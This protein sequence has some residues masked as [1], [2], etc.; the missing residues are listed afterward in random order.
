MTIDPAYSEAVSKVFDRVE[1]KDDSP[2]QSTESFFAFYNRSARV[3]FENIRSFIQI[4]INNY[5][6]NEKK[7]LI[8]RLRSGND[9][10]FRSACFELFLHEILL[11]QG[12]TLLPHPQLPNGSSKK[13]D[14]LVTDPTGERF[15]LEAVLASE[16]SDDDKG[17]AARKSVVLDILAKYPHDNFMI[18][19]DDE[20][21]PKSSPS[22]K[23]LKNEIHAWLDSLEPDK[24]LEKMDSEGF[25][26][27]E[28]MVRNYD[29]WDL[30]IR[31]IPLDPER[32]GQS[33][34]LIGIGGQGGGFIDSW[35]PIRDAIKSKGGKYGELDIPLVV[36]TNVKCF[37][38]D[39]LD[40]M[41]ALFG[42]E[43]IVYQ[44][45]TNPEPKML[46]APNGAWHG[47]N[48]PDYT[49]VSAAWIFND[50]HASSLAH[51]RHTVYFNPW[52]KM[53]APKSLK[54]FPSAQPHF[55]KIVWHEGFSIR[56]IFELDE[57]WPENRLKESIQR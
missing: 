4:C 51:R 49:R 29:G 3:E 10:H 20:G 8:C 24:I 53:P 5:P 6:S 56:E 32:R 13:P 52:A 57:E 2:K 21:S 17:A 33:S 1:R 47:K 37:H 12:F 38:L 35:S 18:A 28:P 14:F 39:R 46:R 15:Y 42:Q 44:R 41:Q 43:Q 19:I 40:E 30:Q 25:D 26:S 45:G 22:G 36:A 55:D 16:K 7:E 31:P 48:G 34:T 23:K 54:R 11:R 9:V 50:L 27:I